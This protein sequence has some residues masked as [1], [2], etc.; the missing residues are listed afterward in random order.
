[1][2]ITM[3]AVGWR[4]VASAA[5]DEAAAGDEAVAIVGVASGAVVFGARAGHV[6]RTIASNS[7]VPRARGVAANTGPLVDVSSTASCVQ[8]RRVDESLHPGVL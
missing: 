1:M 7:R 5:L 8:R 4:V 6:Q 3:H 2:P